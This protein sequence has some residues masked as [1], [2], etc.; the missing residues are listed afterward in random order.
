MF[1]KIL[2]N[3]VNKDAKYIISTLNKVW[4]AIIT[5]LYAILLIFEEISAQNYNMI[6]QKTVFHEDFVTPI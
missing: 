2:Q 4:V 5:S 6:R 1:G 3:Q